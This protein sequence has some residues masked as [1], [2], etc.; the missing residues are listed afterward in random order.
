MIQSK[1]SKG[2]EQTKTAPWTTLLE[3]IFQSTD[4]ITVRL[5]ETW[6]QDGQKHSRFV[7][8]RH[9]DAFSLKWNSHPAICSLAEKERAN[10]F[11]GV[12]PRHG[13]RGYDLAF[14]IRTV[15]CL[16]A[17]LDD[18]AVEQAHQRVADAR[19]AP[20]TLTVRSGGGTHLYWLLA[21][22]YLI[23]DVGDPPQ[24]MK[25]WV[26][27]GQRPRQYITLEDGTK[28]YRHLT[29]PATGLDS[30]WPNPE[31]PGISAKGLTIQA[32]LRGLAARIGGDH[33]IDLP[34]L[35]RL[36]GTF[37]RKDE[38][39][40]RPP[41]PCEVAE[42][43][44]ARRYPFSA[45]EALAAA[46]PGPVPP[47][48]AQ[49]VDL[50]D[51]QLLDK[52]MNA[53]NGALFR[54]LWDGNTTG[55][56][57][58]SEADAALC[59]RLAFWTG[60][61]PSRIERLMNDSALGQRGKWA[62][63]PDYR[64]T[65]IAWAVEHCQEVY[66]PRSRRRRPHRAPGG[67]A[68]VNGQPGPEAPGGTP[69]ANDQPGPAQ[70]APTG[71]DIIITTQAHEVIDEAVAALAGN[72]DL[73]QRGGQLVRVVRLVDGQPDRYIQRSP[74]TPRIMLIAEA[75]LLELLTR[76]ADWWKI[77]KSK[78]AG[79]GNGEGE[80]DNDGGN[81][82]VEFKPALPPFWAV[83]GV[84]HRAVYPN[85][86]CLAGVTECPTIRPDG[87]LVDVPGHDA[88]TGLLYSPSI[89]FPPVPTTPTQEDARRA[90]GVLL[91]LVAEFPF[92]DGPHRA[93]W[94]A[95]VL[96]II[97]RP[98]ID[99]PCPLFLFEAAAAGSGKTLLASLVGLIATGR[100]PPTSELSTDNEE[101]RK[102]ITAIAIEAEPLV[103]LDNASGVLG[104]AALDEAL[105]SRTW[106]GRILGESKRTAELPMR[107]IWLATG[108]NLLLRG[109]T[110]RRV[111]PCRLEPDCERPEERGDYRIPDLPR[112]VVEHRPALVVAVLTMLRAHV[113]AGRPSAEL[114]HYGSYESWGAVVRQAIH[115]ATGLDPCAAR[116]A[117]TADSRQDAGTLTAVLAGWAKLPEGQGKGHAAKEALDLV[118]R[119]P[120]THSGL[121]EA[122]ADWAKDGNELPD[123]RTLAYRLRAARGRVAGAWRL[124]ATKDIH[125]GRSLWWVEEVQ[126]TPS[127]GDGG[128]GGHGSPYSCAEEQAQENSSGGDGG[129]GGH[130]SPSSYA[131]EQAQEEKKEKVPGGESSPPS[132]PSPPRAAADGREE[133]IL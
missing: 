77:G 53:R 133:F 69:P 72:P 31:F 14:Q 83:K 80:K 95:A 82:D 121:G 32:T 45:F 11:Y 131:E 79:E 21:E 64:Q 130:D 22:P 35:M 41:R 29:D 56:K 47:R 49:P 37:N 1:A 6:T 101:V 65:T 132:P 12:C 78:D 9:R 38:R 98:A 24:V 30:R 16:W 63:R 43:D 3:T 33:T 118:K 59:I 116:E 8:E 128:D 76:C 129:D 13:S 67:Q 86:R 111:L 23:D 112:Y 93:T 90:A 97:A 94:L 107:T 105:T 60:R 28:C 34:R 52:A 54:G 115:W 20:A 74:G 122:L 27:K 58:A 18:C 117:I 73:Y 44:P 55:Y 71:R 123:T 114:P 88:V 50:D 85:V 127:G 81:E 120:S 89:E 108:N 119:E 46:A 2:N 126:K 17:D 103:L 96:T 104:C 40:G 84:A 39:N 113:L 109:D 68:T 19:L 48:P 4:R 75:T 57:S 66:E 87:S 36:P 42:C 70:P 100:H 99:G 7:E 51:R 62:G 102:A 15:R 10:I 125:A 92:V 106:K 5:I 26:Q 91:D 25:E 124:R 110:H 61:D